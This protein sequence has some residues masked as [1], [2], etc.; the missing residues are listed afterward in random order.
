MSGLRYLLILTSQSVAL[1]PHRRGDTAALMLSID[2]DI[3]D[4]V[5]AGPKHGSNRTRRGTS[6][7]CHLM[8]RE[9]L[10]QVRLAVA[11]LETVELL[12]RRHF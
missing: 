11:E 12:V 9:A 2:A 4:A 1:V 10:T 6:E 7:G 8:R 5:L 3:A